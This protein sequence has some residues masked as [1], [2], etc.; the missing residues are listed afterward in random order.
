MVGLCVLVFWGFSGL[1]EAS[2]SKGATGLLR[3]PTTETLSA[4]SFRIGYHYAGGENVGSLTLGV[5]P[6]V[7]ASVSSVLRD[8]LTAVTGHAKVR[9]LDEEA[10]MPALA[11]GVESYTDGPGFYAVAS[12]QVGTPMLRAHVGWGTQQFNGF[13]GGVGFLVNPV[14]A[15]SGDGLSIPP[16][17]AAVEYDGKKWHT[18]VKMVFTEE[19][20]GKLY[21][22]DFSAIG[23]NVSYTT[24]F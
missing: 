8:G 21:V 16:T 9:V 14:S 13:F 1:G 19:F 15:R 23:F 18:G 6:G 17:T 7:E 10:T 11:L 22:T 12:K 24:R 3:I 5:Y 20:D 4:G 2:T